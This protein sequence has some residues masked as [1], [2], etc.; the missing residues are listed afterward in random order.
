MSYDLHVFGPTAPDVAAA[1]DALGANNLRY[2][3]EAG[4]ELELKRGPRQLCAVDG[5]LALDEHEDDVPQ[6]AAEALLSVT[7]TVQLS[8]P[9][10]PPKRDAEYVDRYARR[11][12]DSCEGVVYDPQLD[13]VV[14]PRS[15]GKLRAVPKAAA[16]EPG[17]VHLQ[18]CFARDLTD[19]DGAKLVE[20]LQRDLPEALPRRFGTYE[21][22]QGKLAD[23]GA[24][25]FAELFNGVHTVIWKGR[26]PHQWAFANPSRGWGSAL[27]E[28]ERLKRTPTLGGRRAFQP[29]TLKIEVDAAVADSEQWSQAIERL[30]R[31][32]SSA[33]RPFFAG[34][35]LQPA[36]PE[37]WAFLSGLY[38]LGLPSEP[39][40]LTWVGPPYLDHLPPSPAPTKLGPGY[41]FF[42]AG[43]GPRDKMVLPWDGELVREGGQLAQDKAARVIPPVQ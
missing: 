23:H 2:S 41:A 22:L 32:V 17:A 14:W 15:V 5:P 3:P 9:H 20:V 38:W 25:A 21:P 19:A 37:G 16:E 27:S 35:L 31:S 6:A 26:R 42:R 13:Q 8:R 39:M 36:D 29:D 33:L 4:L 43:P 24:P 34:T 40:W 30:F 28:E 11:L 12:A 7:A 1:A 18:W 10:S